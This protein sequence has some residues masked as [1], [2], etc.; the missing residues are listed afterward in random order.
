[1]SDVNKINR[2]YI[3]DTLTVANKNMTTL[4]FNNGL[5]VSKTL[6]S[7]TNN[8]IN[9]KEFVTN[10]LNLFYSSGKCITYEY[11]IN[12][13]NSNTK[14]EGRDRFGNQLTNLMNY[15]IMVFVNGYKLLDS[16]YEIIDDNTLLI[17]NK[18]TD[19]ITSKVI[20]YLCQSLANLGKVTDFDNWN[21]DLQTFSITDFN[22][23]CFMFFKNGQLLPRDQ[24]TYINNTITLNTPIRLGVDIIECYRL[25]SDTISCFFYENT[26]YLTYGPKDAYNTSIP[27]LYDTIA[28]VSLHI[29]RLSIDNVRPGMLIKEETGNGTLLIVDN[30][31]ETHNIKCIAL[32][33]FSKE[34]YNSQEYFIQVPNARDILNYIS[35]YDLSNKLLPETLSIFQVVLLNETYDSVQRLKDIRSINKVD[36]KNLSALINFMGVK[37]NI[38]NMTLE[39]KHALLEELTNFYNIVGTQ[40]SY[41]IY[42]M[43]S[44]DSKI[45]DI[46]QLFT[47]IR[48]ID[49]DKDYAHRYVTFR[50]AEELGA[51]THREYRYP[52]KD[53]GDV[54]TLANAEDS[55]TNTPRDMGMLEDMQ[56][57][58][59]NLP[60]Q[61]YLVPT[62]KN[63]KYVYVTDNTGQIV[64]KA[65]PTK[66]N[67]YT[68]NPI[69][70]PNLPTIDYG[71]VY[72]DAT[73]FYDYG[74]VWEDIKGEW[75][76]WFEWTRPTNWYP[77]NHV[78][79]S[80]EVPP[81]IDYTTFMDEFKRIFYDIA[82]T[83]LYIHGIVDV[84]TF[85]DDE[86]WEE[87]AKP[88]F[89]IMTSQTYHE[90]EYT[91]TNNP[92]LK[93]FIP[94]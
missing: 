52:V 13:R 42:N 72:N 30:D 11:N 31:F 55:L 12:L 9:L 89:G 81:G 63:I 59:V 47:P 67:L 49:S 78:N 20:I 82:S 57:G 54:G 27:I 83:V 15:N 58:T 28:N 44:T 18:Y 19:V 92:N 16:Q 61:T 51:I 68:K 34:T 88:T 70:G 45:I 66:L 75:V 37:L 80:V 71:Y 4:V 3:E 69:V 87:G 33:P 24:I 5:I 8:Q 38:K 60:G 56:R 25:E 86:L 39:E 79:V 35:K 64:E 29:A 1:M 6:Y 2:I 84:Y 17:K 22:Q 91:F 46:E 50:T 26:G 40:T 76:E 41:N 65:I 7:I 21:E 62:L 23:S 10:Y 53:Y 85:G 94:L 48:N 36:S 93:P 74:Y 32:Y 77:T 90:I 73:S 43:M 14:I